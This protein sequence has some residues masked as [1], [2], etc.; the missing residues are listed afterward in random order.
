MR[1]LGRETPEKVSKDIKGFQKGKAPRFI[2]TN[3]SVFSDNDNTAL[4]LPNLKDTLR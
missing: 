2:R 1:K 4:P 3:T